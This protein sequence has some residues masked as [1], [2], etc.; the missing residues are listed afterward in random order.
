MFLKANYVASKHAVIGLTKTGAIDYATDGIR[1]N[2]IG[3]GFIYT[4]LVN[5]QI[6]GIETINLL[7][8]KHPMNR[9]GEPHQIAALVIFLAS[10]EA[11]FITASF[12]PVDGGY[13][14]V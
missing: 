13:L 5:E 14:A 2:A 9:L 10:D 11:S 12:Y 3:P 8:I 1:V 4:G 7:E 6:M